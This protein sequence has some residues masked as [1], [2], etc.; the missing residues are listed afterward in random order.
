MK[1]QNCGVGARI[2]AIANQK[3]GVGKTITAINLAAALALRGRRTLLIDLDPQ[4]HVGVGLGIDVEALAQTSYQLLVD[5]SVTVDDVKVT[6]P[7][8]ALAA[9]DVVPSNLALALAADVPTLA[10]AHKLIAVRDRYDEIVIDCPPALSRVTLNAF[11]A[12]DVVVIPVA[13]G[14]FSIHGVRMLA[15]TLKEI[16]EATGL[17]YDIRCLITRYR[18][19]QSVSREVRQAADEL[20]GEYCFKAVVRE[21]IDVERSVGAQTPLVLYTP[22]SPAAKDYAALAVEVLELPVRPAH[23]DDD[24]A[25]DV[26]EDPEEVLALLAKMQ[27]AEGEVRRGES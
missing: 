23:R 19:G 8:P 5:P 14:F 25:I 3:G 18:A 6:A 24:F 1:D 27:S 7:F 9:L 13:V 21:H 10:L 15:L 16:F 17:D 4:G 12:C 26:V 22:D 20:F 2:L 11:L